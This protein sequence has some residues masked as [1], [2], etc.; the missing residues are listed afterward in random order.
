MAF[1]PAA[2]FSDAADFVALLAADLADLAAAAV[3]AAVLR[4]VA[5]VRAA[6]W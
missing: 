5:D 2:F 6:A 1:G 3:R 4:A